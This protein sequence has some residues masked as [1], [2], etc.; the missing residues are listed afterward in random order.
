M[1]FSWVFRPILSATDLLICL[2]FIE[3]NES[4]HLK[5]GTYE[6][7]EPGFSS[8]ALNGIP[9][10]SA[11]IARCFPSGTNNISP[12]FPLADTVVGADIEFL[13]DSYLQE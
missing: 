3:S 10:I 11:Q 8:I 13:K 6:Y 2:T 7:V 1:S 5:Q 4:K 12:D 9:P